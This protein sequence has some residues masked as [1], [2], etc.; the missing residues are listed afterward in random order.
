VALGKN[1]VAYLLDRASLGGESAAHALQI[2]CGIHA[3]HNQRAG[4][5]YPDGHVTS[6]DLETIT[7]I[8]RPNGAGGTPTLPE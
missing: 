1:G 2:F 4:L 6:T 8:L 7:G 5:W 3:R